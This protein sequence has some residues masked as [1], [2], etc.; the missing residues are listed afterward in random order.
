MRINYLS[1]GCRFC[2][3]L[4]GMGLKVAVVGATG[5]V[6]R[7][8]LM[9]ME[10]R[11]FQVEE[12]FLFVSDR[13]KG[14]TLTFKGESF[15]VRSLSKHNSFKGIDI[16]LFSA[17]SS[18]SGE[19]ALRFAR[20]G[21]VVIDNSSAWRLEPDVPLVVPEVNPED[22]NNYIGI[23]ANPNCSSIQMVVA[24]KPI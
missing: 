21:A 3:K 24:L 4:S 18:V 5:E 20:Y 16:A 13:S 9:V 22:V 1:P 6:V 7:A 19:Y 2:D 10:E 12:L 8:F 17:E 23:I 15:K 14:L 11:N